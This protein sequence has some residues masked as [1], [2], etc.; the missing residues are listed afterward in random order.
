[1]NIWI[2]GGLDGGWLVAQW[3]VLKAEYCI[4]STTVW[5]TWALPYQLK[6]QI[7]SSGR[8]VIGIEEAMQQWNGLK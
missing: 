5:R 3:L 1:M 7:L 8:P 4:P 6:I 2:I